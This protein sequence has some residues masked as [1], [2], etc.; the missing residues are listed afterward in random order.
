MDFREGFPMEKDENFS[1]WFDKVLLEANVLDGRYPVKGFTVYRGWGFQIVR[2]ISRMLEERLEE[3]GHEPMLFPV[4]IPEETFEKE[5]EHIKGFASEVFWITK[6]GDTELP[7]KLLLRPTSETAIYPLFK[8]WIRSHADLPLKMHQTCTIYRY[9][10][11]AT[12]HLFRAREFLW[13][14]AHTAH[15]TLE[16]ADKQ[17]LE[18]A[19]IYEEM[20]RRLCL[21][22][23][24]LRR[25]DFDKFPGAVYSIAFDAWNPDGKANQIGTV[26]NLG[27]KFAKSFEI[28]YED[29][30]GKQKHVYQTCYG[31]GIGRVLAAIIAQHGDDHGLV[32]PPEVAPIQVVIVPIPYKG[33]EESLKKPLHRTFADPEKRGNQ[34]LIRRQRQDA[35]GREILSLGDAG[36]SRPAGSGPQRDGSKSVDLG[37]ERHVEKNIDSTRESDS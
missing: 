9:E 19:E 10:T 8:I 28:T 14:E 18:G 27:D 13:N 6:G 25:P 34:K 36:C 22:Y 26:H 11:K 5:A 2:A 4:V 32:L 16:E 3:N 7:R 37:T 23:L 29:D 24:L 1:D 33:Y 17:V 21:S 30:D 20:Y 12:R 15:A 35:T 31:F